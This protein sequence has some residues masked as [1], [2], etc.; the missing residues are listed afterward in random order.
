[1]T[2]DPFP[3]PTGEV[4]LT[5]VGADR[6]NVGDEVQ[7][8]IESIEALG[9]TTVTLHE[10]FLDSDLEFTGVPVDMVLA[11]AGVGANEGLTWIALD[12]YQVFYTRSE[13]AHDHALVATRQNGKPIPVDEGGPIRVVFI[14]ADGELGRD[15][16]QWIWGVT[17]V[18]VG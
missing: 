8:D 3:A 13:A 17:H 15:T 9:A 7:L 11:A 10:P 12:E 6:P 14:E 16:N 4:V 5:I 2:L 18:D 1:M